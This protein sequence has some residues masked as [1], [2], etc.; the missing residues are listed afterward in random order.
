ML[1]ENTGSSI[2]CVTLGEPLM[3]MLRKLGDRRLIP[4]FKLC[5]ELSTCT[6]WC[7]VTFVFTAAP[8]GPGP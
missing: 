4:E 1:T 8:P 6:C 7:T 3:P 2:I 5:S